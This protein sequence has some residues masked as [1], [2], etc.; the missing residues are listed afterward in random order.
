MTAMSHLTDLKKNKVLVG[1][2][3]GVDS[4]VAAYLL[5]AKGYDVVGCTIK[6]W[7]G[8][9]GENSRCCETDDAARVCDA[10]GMPYYVLDRVSDFKRLVIDPFVDAYR[11]AITPNPCVGCNR[12]IKWSGL[13]DAADRFGAFYVATGHYAFVDRLDNGRFTVRGASST[14]KD[15]S[16]MLWMLTQPQLERTLTPLGS[17]TKDEVRRIAGSVGLPV[18]DK[19]D[20]QEICFVPDGDYADLVAA[21]S[22]APLPGDG[23]FVDARGDRL[24]RHRGIIHYTVGQ[25]RGLGV[26][27]DRPLYVNRID[28]DKN[29]VVLS[30]DEELYRDVIECGGLNFMGVPGLDEGEIIRAKVKIRYRHPGEKA[31]IEG[32]DGGRVRVRFD[33]PVRAPAPGQS[34]VFYDADDRVLGGGVIL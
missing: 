21:A 33:S 3:G 2:S 24:G 30:T 6:T 27:S 10:L 8:A 17:L 18:A 15:Q 23:D 32:L 16:Y 7:T 4:A 19:P 29:E 31:L 5:A 20:S 1:M 9:D 22:D 34:A 25:R 14:Q 12:D 13:T 28:A 26:S 11:S